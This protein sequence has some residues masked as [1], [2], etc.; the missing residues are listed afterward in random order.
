MSSKQLVVEIHGTGT[1]NRGAELMAIAIIEQLRQRYSDPLIVVGE[2]FGTVEDLEKYDLHTTWEQPEKLHRYAYAILRR[3]VRGLPYIGESK[4]E[5]AYLR[6]T[7]RFSPKWSRMVDPSRI[8]IVI[9]ASGFAFSDQCAPR[10]AHALVRLMNGRR[11]GKPLLLL[12]QALGPFN[13]PIVANATQE[14]VERA[15]FCMARDAVSLEEIKRLVPDSQQVFLFPDFTPLVDPIPPENAQQIPDDFVAIV[16]NYRMLDKTDNPKVYLEFLANACNAL[17]KAGQEVV[18]VVHDAKEDLKVMKLLEDEIGQPTIF[19]HADPRVLKQVLGRASFV[20]GSRF[21]ALVSSLSGSV[22]C[23]AAGWSHKY[24]ELLK[25]FDCAELHLAELSD[26]Q[27][28][29]ELLTTLTTAESNQAIRRKIHAAVEKT[30]TR[31]QEM[32]DMVFVV[33]DGVSG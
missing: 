12:P 22:P 16:P 28:L 29:N 15:E 32:W 2:R 19:Q 10:N 1:H 17:K 5:K 24:P 21:H 6:F 20:I 30:K 23:I 25:Q 7:K 26:E 13:M 3:L 33:L 14:L 31:I 18:F 27:K 9:D 4:I 11:P 8:D